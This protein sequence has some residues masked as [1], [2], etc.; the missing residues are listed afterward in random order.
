M[1]EN[2][3]SKKILILGF[4]REGIDSFL[5]LRKKFPAAVFG[6]ADE[7][8]LEK[9]SKKAKKIIRK[10]PPTKLHLGKDYLTKVK[11]YDVIIR[12]PGIA[13]RIL[14]PFISQKQILT[15]PTEIF[16]DNCPGEIIGI[17]GT[18]G[19]GTT[20]SLIYRILKK[21]GRKAHLIGNIGKPVLQLL[22]SATPKDI[23]VDELSSHQLSTLKKSPPIAVLLNIYP[24]HL[25]YY[26][27]FKKYAEAKANLCRYQ[28]KSD[29]LIYNR[30]NKTSRE[31]SKKSKA[32]KIPI[33]PKKI[34]K[35]IKIKNIPLKGKFNLYNVGAAIEVGQLYHISS[36]K[37]REAIKTFKPLPHRLEF[38]GTFKGIDFYN[39]S[40][41]TMP[42]ATI[43]AIEALGK[44]IATLIAGGFDRGL[45]FKNV[46]TA[47]LKS[48]I[49][50]LI[51][52]PTTGE[53]IWKEIQIQNAECKIK[54]ETINKAF[55]AKTMEEA[56][57]L[58]YQHTDKKRI[59]LLSCA[60]AS[61]SLFKDYKERGELFKKYVKELA[62]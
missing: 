40:L 24:D 1:L 31:L 6:I 22:L 51:L 62:K 56:V 15:S 17:T 48:N 54:N 44:N 49:K 21:G 53:K 16:F 4:G 55:S 59:C 7:L 50:T 37:I 11:D 32:K 18:K 28:K 5:F 19:K 26:G 25:D 3:K 29:F 60:S 9:L 2:F 46:A 41:A 14:S 34:E 10:Y 42:E 58:S 30:E 27:T 43:A 61:F 33:N 23:Y 45:S 39:D 52:F 36:K 8:K 57:V 13:P 38:V 12:S 35:I 20:S 47:I